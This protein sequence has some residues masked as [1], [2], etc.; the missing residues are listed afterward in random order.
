MS[1]IIL[2][3]IAVGLL[4]RCS[5]LLQPESA[6]KP[7]VHNVLHYPQIGIEP[8]PHVTC[9]DKSSAAAEMGD[10]P[11]NRHGPTRGVGLLCPFRG[12]IGPRPIQCGLGRGLLPYQVES[13]SIQPSG[14]NSQGPKIGWGG[15]AFF[16]GVAGSQWNTKSP[17]QRPTS[18]PSGTLVLSAV[19]P[20]RTLAENWG[21]CPLGK[22]SWVPI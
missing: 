3:R 20:Q 21:M 11:H 9:T 14:H 6:T 12:E 5:L 17:E 2:G 13:S 18:I 22:G 8:R 1:I 19:W 4:R 16:L 7:E 15:C 10:R